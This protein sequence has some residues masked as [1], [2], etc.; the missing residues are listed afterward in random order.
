MKETLAPTKA[1]FSREKPEPR[2]GWARIQ[3]GRVPFGYA[4]VPFEEVKTMSTDFRQEFDKFLHLAHGDDFC[5][6]WGS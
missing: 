2:D 6:Y 3:N 4:L 5:W 1:I